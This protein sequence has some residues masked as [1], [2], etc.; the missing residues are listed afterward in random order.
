MKKIFVGFVV[1]ISL[2]LPLIAMDAE[3][4]A[5]QAVQE[6]MGKSVHAMKGLIAK[7]GMNLNLN[8][9]EIDAMELPDLLNYLNDNPELAQTF[10]QPGGLQWIVPLLDE[11]LDVAAAA[12]EGEEDIE[13]PTV[14]EFD[15]QFEQGLAELPAMMQAIGLDL[16]DDEFQVLILMVSCLLKQMNIDELDA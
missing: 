9:E 15:D 16:D 4:L 10:G 2:A 8:Q 12:V 6:A 13:I 14:A 11:E 5:A 1:S 3:E 7:L